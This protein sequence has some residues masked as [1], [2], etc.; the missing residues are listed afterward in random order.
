MNR[1]RH[2]RLIA[3]SDDR[4]VIRHSLLVRVGFSAFATL[5]GGFLCSSVVKTLRD[6]TAASLLT[7]LAMLAVGSGFLSVF[8]RMRVVA[9]AD[10]LHLRNF[11]REHHHSV[12]TIV[13]V[14][15]R[16]ITGGSNALGGRLAVMLTN[17]RRLDLH[18]TKSGPFGQAGRDRQLRQLRDW[19]VT[20]QLRQ[21][22][23]RPA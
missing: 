6:G 2:G 10:G 8:L 14:V 3:V 16:P 22:G 7:E 23:L 11:F 5:W 19:L 18:V 21:A 13:Q 12:D 20:Q 9:D 1:R 17:G 4:I 15:D